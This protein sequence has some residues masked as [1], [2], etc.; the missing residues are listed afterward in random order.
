MVHTTEAIIA[1]GGAHIPSVKPVKT[2]CLLQFTLCPATSMITECVHATSL[3]ILWM[4]D[5]CSNIPVVTGKGH[6]RYS[7]RKNYILSTGYV[8]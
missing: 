3:T 5:S 1:F 2:G 7:C 8:K 4:N 6:S